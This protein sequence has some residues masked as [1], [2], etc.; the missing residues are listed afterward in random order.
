MAEM[1]NEQ[2]GFAISD[3]DVAAFRRDGVLL[4]R[5]VF[6]DW[7][8]TLRTGIDAN[9]A[10]PSW[11]IRQYHP[12]DSPTPF[13]QDFCI[14]HRIPE[15]RDFIFNS[16]AGAV[17]ARLMGAKSVRLFHE[18]ILVKEPG[19]T[20]ETPWHQDMPYY[21]VDGPQT[22]SMWIALDHVARDTAVEYVAGSH[23]WGREFRPD[24]F[25][26]SALTEGDTRERIPDIKA[27]R[28]GYDIRGWAVEPGDAIAFDF[29]TVHGAPANLNPERRR[30]AFS[31]RVV[32]DGTVYVERGTQS[33]PFPDID[34]KPGQPLDGPDFPVIWTA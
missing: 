1:L 22:C 8:E 3:P 19:A 15:F 17:A 18:H 16:P 30:R 14:W 4:L 29:R 31:L 13:F 21:C 33:P 12:D 9:I 34:L 20:V 2:D 25:D 27:N 10:E 11:R 6:A 5:G 28:A 23:R 26:G 7:V 24:R 32:G